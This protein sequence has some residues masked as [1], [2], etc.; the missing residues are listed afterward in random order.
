MGKIVDGKALA[1]KVFKDL[2]QHPFLQKA[3]SLKRKIVIIAVDPTPETLTFIKLKI[4]AGQE[5]GLECEVRKL[6]PE[7]TLENLVQAIKELAKAQG[8]IGIIIQLPVPAQLNACAIFNAVPFQKDIDVLS[9]AG[10]T[11]FINFNSEIAPPVVGAIRLI[12]QQEKIELRGK[13]VAVLGAGK[14]IGIPALAWF[15]G[16]GALVC[17]FNNEQRI[18]SSLLKQAEVVV[19]GF[20]KP[21]FL[22]K[23]MVKPGVAV[24]DAGY[25]LVNGKPTGDADFESLK[26]VVS[27]ITLVPGGIGPLT[28]SLIFKN[29]L[30]LYKKYQVNEK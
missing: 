18:V 11:N 9:E 2:K 5:L 15:A 8:F 20:G 19:C 10:Y 30:E 29:A 7:I 26:S 24:F 25:S 13:L 14:L 12:C 1:Q 6:P 4:K 27:L 16:Q 21:G 22:K 23:E 17:S 28:V 3:V